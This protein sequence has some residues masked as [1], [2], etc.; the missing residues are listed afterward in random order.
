MMDRQ[1]RVAAT[2]ATEKRFKDRPFDWTK[3]STCVHLMRFHA[4]QMGHKL[5]I[6]PK[7]R[8]P[9]GAKRALLNMGH[10]DLPS[11]LDSLFIRAPVLSLRVGDII[12]A[13]GNDGFHAILI[14]GEKTKYL[15]WHEDAK[16]CTIVDVDIGK[17]IGGWHL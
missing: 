11:L 1:R 17:V 2:I 16:G 6:V 15:G 9:F 14:K 3:A 4:A 12:A 13:D 8:S 5:P 7:F 10:D